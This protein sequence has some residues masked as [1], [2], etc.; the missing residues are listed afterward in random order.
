MCR[1]RRPG[2]EM[3][4]WEPG[5]NLSLAGL[6]ELLWPLSHRAVKATARFQGHL[7][8]KLAGHPPAWHLLL[9]AVWGG[10]GPPV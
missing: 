9:R 2:L 6:R 10:P 3:V 5:C 4:T 1:L 7:S 8:R